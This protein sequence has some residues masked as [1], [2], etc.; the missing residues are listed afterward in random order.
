MNWHASELLWLLFLVPLLAAA[1]LLGF[2][3]RQAA[4]SGDYRFT[5]L[6]LPEDRHDR[7][8]DGCQPR[9]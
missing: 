5:F 4:R 2:R 9:R 7:D 1:L 3:I 8:V 6:G